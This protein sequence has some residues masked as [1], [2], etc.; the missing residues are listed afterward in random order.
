M[1]EDERKESAVAFL[2]QVVGHY[3]ACGIRL[4]RVMTDNGP[5]YRSR[6]LA[7]ACRRLQLRHPYTRP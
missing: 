2:E 1:A 6:D 4:R 7:D 3:R 5:A